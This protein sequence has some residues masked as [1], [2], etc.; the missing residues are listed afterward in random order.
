MQKNIGTN[1]RLLRVAIA[2]VLIA[3]IAAGWLSPLWTT[4]AAIVALALLV[5]S[6]LSFCPSYLPF[7]LSTCR[8]EPDRQTRPRA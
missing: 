5:T 3:M 1:D 8:E 4:I 7:N 2:V 6:A